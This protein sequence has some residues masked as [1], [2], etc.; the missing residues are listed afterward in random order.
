M[1]EYSTSF[2]YLE[3]RSYIFILFFWSVRFDGVPKICNRYSIDLDSDFD[4][5][6]P[7]T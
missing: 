6:I 2:G 3:L 1:L 4:H 5:A 7:T